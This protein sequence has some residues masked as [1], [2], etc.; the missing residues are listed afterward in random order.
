MK[1]LKSDSVEHKREGVKG[2]E[3]EIKGFFG[4]VEEYE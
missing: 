1:G 2:T 3:V 4:G